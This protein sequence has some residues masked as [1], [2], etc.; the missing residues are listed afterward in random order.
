M[1]GATLSMTPAQF[2]AFVRAEID[3]WGALAKQA[4]IKAD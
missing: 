4:N 3:K 2:N 1:G